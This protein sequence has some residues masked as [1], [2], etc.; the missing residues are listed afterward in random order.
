MKIPNFALGLMLLSL[1]ATPAWAADD[2]AFE[3]LATCKDSWIDLSKSDPAQ[4]KKFG[5]H[6]RAN[7]SPHGN[8][9]YF[10]PKSTITVGGLRVVQAFPQSV[11]MGLGFSLT[12]DAPF[13]KARAVMEKLTGK[14]LRTCE[15]GDGMRSCEFKIAEQRTI[16]L[17]AGDDPKSSQT[18]VG[19]YYYYEK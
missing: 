15:T 14:T 19:C 4:L 2:V 10:L 13:D 18:L 9:P 3:R 1:A 7:F 5:D 6:F 8:D 16:M 12:V 17:M 11:G